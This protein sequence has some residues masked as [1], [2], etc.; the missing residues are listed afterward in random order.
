MAKQQYLT[1]PQELETMPPGIPYIVGNEAAERFSFYGMKAVLA[2]FMTKYLLDAS[3]APAPFPEETASK[4]IHTFNGAA[5]FFPILGAFLADWLLGKYRTILSLSLLYCVGHGVLALMDVNHLLGVDQQSLLFVG[6]AIIA[7]GAGGI[8]PCVASHVG[9][10]FGRKNEHLL[11]V[12]FSWFY[13]S[14]NLGATVAILLTPILRDRLGIGWAFGVPAVLMAI[15]TFAFWMGRNKFVHIPPSGGELFRTTISPAGRQALL[16]L[17][18]LYLFVAMFWALF[19]QTHSRWVMQA[20]KMDRNFGFNLQPTS[21]QLQ[22]VNSILVLI[23]I[24]LTALVIYPAL[25]KLFALTPLRKIGLGLFLAAPAFATSALIETAIQSGAT[26]HA[27]WQILAYFFITMA[28]ILISIT[29]MEFS[30]TQA[31]NKMKS[32][33]LG[34]F[35]LSVSLG[36]FYTAAVNQW[37]ESSAAQGTPVLQ[38]AGY[39][40]FFTA[41]MFMTAVLFLLW[42]PFYRGRTYI[43]SDDAV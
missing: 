42:S 2:V 4:W 22:A 30:Y 26:P 24:P 28:E 13:F 19:D 35:Y 11:P 16:N 38:G 21:D 8:K 32:V 9:D 39:Y 20:E 14:I 34:C 7:V 40:W 5:Y 15:A 12:V 10:Q 37:I 36:N 17:F 3:G 41:S 27:G 43:Q 6:L 33:M 25:G 29:A 18:P 31:P 1:R 23:M